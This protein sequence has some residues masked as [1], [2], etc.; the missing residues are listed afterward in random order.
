MKKRTRA[1]YDLFL[2]LILCAPFIVIEINV[3][4][5]LIIET[6]HESMLENW[7]LVISFAISFMIPFGG[8]FFLR[9]YTIENGT[10]QFYYFPFTKSSGSKSG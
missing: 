7:Y 6:S 10:M 4:V 9:Y 5:M 8:A 3:L 2:Y 1:F